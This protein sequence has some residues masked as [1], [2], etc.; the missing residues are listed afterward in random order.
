[1]AATRS[2]FVCLHHRSDSERRWARK[3]T[4]SPSPHECGRHRQPSGQARSQIRIIR[5]AATRRRFVLLH[6]RSGSERRWAMK[7]IHSPSPHECG[8]HRQPSGQARSQTRIIRGQSHEA[9]SCSFGC[10]RSPVV[11]RLHGHSVKRHRMTRKALQLPSPLS[12]QRTCARATMSRLHV[13]SRI[14]R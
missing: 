5:M 13:P 11:K 7:Q 1:M 12:P 3:Q 6:Y 8:R 9:K 2:R 10:S 14:R 4:H